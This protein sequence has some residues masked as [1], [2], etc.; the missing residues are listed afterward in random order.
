LLELFA[1]GWLQ[2]S[3]LLISA[4]CEARIYRPEPLYLA[5]EKICMPVKEGKHSSLLEGILKKKL[6]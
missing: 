5:F 1:W 4:S 3:I 2:T 6:P